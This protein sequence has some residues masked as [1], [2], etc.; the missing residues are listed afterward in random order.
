MTW[1]MVRNQANTQKA[2]SLLHCCHLFSRGNY[3]LPKNHYENYSS[4]MAHSH[5]WG[6]G[7]RT[8]ARLR[9]K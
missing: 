1:H 3:I 9:A 2:I 8:K 4:Q 7:S 5:I 6:H